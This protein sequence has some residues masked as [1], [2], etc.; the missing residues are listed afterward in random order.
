VTSLAQKLPGAQALRERSQNW[1][2]SRIRRTDSQLL[3]QRNVYILPTGAGL[4]FAATVLVLLLASINYQL[5]LGYVLSFLLAG[6]G[7]VSMHLTHNTLRGLTLILKPVAPAFAGQAAP[8]EVV[9]SGSATARHGIGLKLADAAHDSLVWIDVPDGGQTLAHLSFTPAL[10]GR[11]EVPTL[12]AETRFPLGLFRAWTVWRPASTQWVYPAPESD[13]PA[14]PPAQPAPGGAVGVSR[15]RSGEDMEGV[16][17]YQRGDPLK[18]VVWKKAAKSMD[19]GGELVVRDTSA[20]TQQRLTLDWHACG[21]LP[22]EAR[23][24]RLTAWCLAAHRLGVDWGLSLPG[25]ELAPGA[26]ENQRRAALE[27]LALWA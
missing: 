5:N 19:A 24:S 17:A 8:L 25:V 12:T 26:G 11:H 2:N 22:A 1:F 21:G 9:V 3:T 15:S 18:W 7:L 23:L 13:A 16:R 14:L 27:A 20:V 10:R 6:A 4:M